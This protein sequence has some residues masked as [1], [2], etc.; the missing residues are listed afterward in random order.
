MSAALWRPTA[1]EVAPRWKSLAT[2]LHS[3][4]VDNALRYIIFIDY[5]MRAPDDQLA[6]TL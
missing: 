6:T 3:E 5:A 2:E 4:D 1:L